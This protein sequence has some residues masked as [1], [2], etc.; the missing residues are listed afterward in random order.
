VTSKKIVVLGTGGTIAGAA[1]D[2]N[3]NVGYKAAQVPVDALL[4]GVLPAS[5]LAIVSEQIAQIDSKDM[6]FEVWRVLARR[7]AHL[8]AQP[9]VGGIVV[10]HGTDTMEET[11]F[12]LHSVLDAAK[13]VVLT[14][15]MRPATALSAD[16]PRNLR[17]ALTVATTRGAR[18]VV[19][20]FAGTVHAASD[21]AK[22]HT[23]RLDPFSSGDAGPTGYVE[24]GRVRLLKPW[25]VGT[26][27]R[28]TEAFEALQ[29]GADW[30]RVE[31]VMNHVGAGAA[32]VDGLAQQGVQGIVAAGT[33]N[34]SLHADLEDAL[35]RAQA[36]GV[37][38]LRA[39]RCA[40]GPL[41]DSPH[42]RL[43]HADGLPPVKARIALMLAL[44]APRQPEPEARAT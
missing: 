19:V 38:V 28:A 43:A 15:A 16:G 27:A 40:Q 5:E 30:P 35:L 2:S 10:T 37:H 33:G 31:I 11:A 7:C 12:F 21:V 23:Y 42:D 32:I 22:V 6:S 17:D 9:G 4:H 14:G 3:D 25:P 39:S 18:G 13:P 36:A 29:H 1:A 26:G 20:V 34:G 24:E 41:L 8:L 44:M